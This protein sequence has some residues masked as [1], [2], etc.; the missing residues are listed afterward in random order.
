MGPHPSI[1]A[2]D[3]GTRSPRAVPNLGGGAGF[4][5]AEESP[6]RG[7]SEPDG[8]GRRYAPIWTVAVFA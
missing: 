3:V 6:R 4:Q 7:R 2:D 1:K 8:T 5:A